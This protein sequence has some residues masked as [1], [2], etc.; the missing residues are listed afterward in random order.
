MSFWDP[1]S[2]AAGARSKVD[3]PNLRGVFG[4]GAG[5]EEVCPQSMLELEFV[6]PKEDCFCC[7]VDS[8]T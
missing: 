5:F 3:W 2:E 8:T 6:G 7:G 4:C 1:D